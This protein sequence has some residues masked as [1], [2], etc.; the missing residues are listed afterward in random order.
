MNALV[1]NKRIYGY[2][3]GK[4]IIVLSR[5]W[6]VYEVKEKFRD[7]GNSGKCVTS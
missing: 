4:S 5:D 2:I 1:K 6:N 7:V 3:G